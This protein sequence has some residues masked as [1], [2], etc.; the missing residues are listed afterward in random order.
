MRDEKPD[1]LVILDPNRPDNNITGGSSEYPRISGLF[2]RV[3]D[4][5][6]DRLDEFADRSPDDE[7]FSF[8]TDV[9]GGDFSAYTSQRAAL[10]SVYNRGRNGTGKR[11]R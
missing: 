11:R 1:R 3:Y 4:S 8:L 5:I 6:S 2:S 9:I 7:Q 10:S